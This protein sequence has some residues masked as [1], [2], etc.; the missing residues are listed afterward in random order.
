MTDDPHLRRYDSTKGF[1]V[2]FLI[3]A[4]A[5]LSGAVLA[6]VLDVDSPLWVTISVITVVFLLAVWVT[7][8]YSRAATILYE[9]HILIRTAFRTRRVAWE[10]VQEIRNERSPAAHQH[11]V[12]KRVMVL[13]DR[14]G[15]M[16]LLPHLTE[17]AVS[18]LDTELGV[19]RDSW[20][21]RRGEDWERNPT[22]HCQVE[23]SHSQVR[24]GCRA[25]GFPCRLRGRLCRVARAR[26]VP[27]RGPHHGRVGRCPGERPGP[28]AR[29]HLPGGKPYGLHTSGPAPQT[30][31]NVTRL[32]VCVRIGE[33][34]TT[35]RAAEEHG[36]AIAD[37][38]GREVTELR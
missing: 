12:P 37:Q 38:V 21:R 3:P 35:H 19:L 27:H 15:R 11:I 28:C 13:Y 25:V 7:A 31:P 10:D 18:S 29:G 1:A 4:S 5:P 36:T 26:V 8:A 14:G 30:P 34:S 22:G 23:R 33:M 17:W 20:I 9:D 2:G 6:I 24:K 32:L 16:F